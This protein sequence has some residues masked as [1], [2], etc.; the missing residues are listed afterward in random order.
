M[1]KHLLTGV[2]LLSAAI[3]FGQIQRLRD[4]KLEEFRCRLPDVKCDGCRTSISEELLKESG[5]RSVRFAGEDR[6]ELVISHTS[7]RTGESLQTSLARIGYSAESLNGDPAKAV[8][9][10]ACVCPT[11]R[12]KA[13]YLKP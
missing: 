5:I 12:A 4:G 1:K 7:K 8:S 3:A 2:L 13:G 10:Q 6:K 11:E 9:H